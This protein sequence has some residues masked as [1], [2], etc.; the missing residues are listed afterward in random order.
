M[1]KNLDT[2]FIF[3]N[4]LLTKFPG[5]E[6]NEKSG[7]EA[8]YVFGS[9]LTCGGHSVTQFCVQRKSLCT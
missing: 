8:T 5:E 3:I 1:L 4:Y 9:M 7:I 6:E 2:P